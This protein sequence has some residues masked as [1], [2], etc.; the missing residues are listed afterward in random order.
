MK[1][2]T[3]LFAALVLVV[4]ITATVWAQHAGAS[5]N[6]TASCT[7]I[8]PLAL[9]QT[10]SLNFGAMAVQSSSAGTCILS[11]GGKRS[12]TGGVNLSSQ[13]TAAQNAAF[14]VSGMASTAYSLTLPVTVTIYSGG[15]NMEISTLLVRF[16]GKDSDAITS[17][18]SET[19]SDSF[20]IGGT[21]NVIASQNV[22]VY[23]GTFPVTV[24]YN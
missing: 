19:G 23:E 15:K 11:S 24:A 18:L 3:K 21:L 12:A 9:T 13:G 6:A 14:S 2:L 20:T 10:S 17:T 4:F 22:G 8:N 5:A 1:T 16:K 7:I